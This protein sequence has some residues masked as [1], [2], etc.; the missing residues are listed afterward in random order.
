[1]NTSYYQTGGVSIRKIFIGLAVVILFVAGIAI[2]A[3]DAKT[4]Q[5]EAD[6]PTS[7]T[8]Q[9]YGTW[10]HYGLGWGSILGMYMDE[11]Y[12]YAIANVPEAGLFHQPLPAAFSW[13]NVAIYAGDYTFTGTFSGNSI[14]GWI[15]YGTSLAGDWKVYMEITDLSEPDPDTGTVCPNLPPLYVTGDGEECVE[16]LPFDP[17]Y[18]TGYID[19]PV[20]GET[21]PNQYRSY[22]RRDLIQVVKYAAAKVSCKTSGWDYWD[23]SPIGLIDMSEVDG[24]IP[25]TSVGYPGHPPGTH[26]NGNDMDLAYYQLYVDDNHGRVVGEHHE[27]YDD[28]Y[29]LTGEPHALDPWRTALFIAY[30]S[31]HHHL[32]VIGVDGQVGP[33]IEDALDDLVRLGYI[34]QE[35]RDSIPLMYEVTDQGYGWFRFHH[36]HMHISMDLIYDIVSEVDLKPDSLNRK[37]GGKYI[38]GYIELD[39][40]YDVNDIDISTLELIVNGHTVVP[41]D[42][43]H[44]RITDYN[45]NDIP[46]LTIKFDRKLVADAIGMGTVEVAITGYV[47]GMVFQDS[48]T[49]SVIK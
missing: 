13:P 8:G 33:V 28:A 35:L 4:Y 24:S 31:E 7:L 6:V 38:T 10:Y 16:L 27:G 49:I 37:S 3:S 32:R 25:G 39:E 2:P 42:E 23:Y 15:W 21:W 26:E 34:D 41:A 12:G 20:N 9:W 18:G 22:A 36:H 14:S 29:H 44:V 45:D 43:D 48:D 1:M 19:Y 30:L 46:D 40:G 11:D 5:S 47:D 17:D